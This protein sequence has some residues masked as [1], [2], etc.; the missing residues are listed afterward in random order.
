M[1]DYYLISK[2]NNFYIFLHYAN[3]KNYNSKLD[4][5]LLNVVVSSKIKLANA[6]KNSK[7][8][9]YTI[10]KQ[11]L[12]ESSKNKNINVKA[13]LVCFK[14]TYATGFRKY[15]DNKVLKILQK[16]CKRIKLH[17]SKVIQ[18][19]NFIYETKC[20]ERKNDLMGFPLFN[21]SV[22]N[23]KINF[24]GI[25]YY[26]V[27]MLNEFTNTNK[28]FVEGSQSYIFPINFNGKISK[29]MSFYNSVPSSKKGNNTMLQNGSLSVISITNCIL[30]KLIFNESTIK[31]NWE[32]ISFGF[33]RE[34]SDSTP[35]QQ[36]LPP[37]QTEILC[38]NPLDEEL[39]LVVPQEPFVGELVPPVPTE[40]GQ[41][42]NYGF[43]PRWAKPGLGVIRSSIFTEANNDIK[44]PQNNMI[45]E[46]RDYS[47]IFKQTETI[48]LIGGPLESLF[49][50]SR[51]DLCDDIFYEGDSTMDQIEIY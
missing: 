13:T 18:M 8:L 35:V 27:K 32:N 31:D 2:T 49:N 45:I 17:R 46:T 19:Y 36:T 40:I 42:R 50:K 33:T 24:I 47:H 23:G 48:G 1:E 6:T 25:N 9:V 34:D 11:T 44:V 10:Y 43:V 26:N 22:K 37:A 3:D 28:T 5:Q 29:P 21:D 39:P 14:Q 12:T 51:F 4:S 16:T 15:T 38:L 7:C 30:T 20:F 41:S